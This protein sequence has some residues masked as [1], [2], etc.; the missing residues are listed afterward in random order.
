[1]LVATIWPALTAA[2][3]PEELESA[4]QQSFHSGMEALVADLN[5]SSYRSLIRSIDQADM[6]ERIYG[7]RLIDQ[8]VKKRFG[9]RLEYTW[10]DLIRSGFPETEDG[11]AATLLGVES[12]GD[13]GRAVVRFDLPDYQFGYHEYDLRLG[14]SGR[15]FV[16]DWIDYLDGM[17]FSD[18]VGESLVMGMPSKPAMRK[19]LDFRNVSDVELFQ[20]GELLKAA[21]DG[22]LTRYLEI[23]E[24]MEEKFQRQRIV[25]ENTVRVAKRVRKRR[26]MLAGLETM[27]K[28]YPDDPLYALMLLDYYFPAHKY[29]EATRALLGA[30]R[31]LG[32]D[33]AAMEARLSAAALVQGNAQ[34]AAGYA[35]RALELEPGLELAWW[36]ALNARATLQDFGAAVEALEFLE[37]EF[38][39]ELTPAA[40]GRDPTY[41]GLLASAE[42]GAWRESRQ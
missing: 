21:R 25:V 34:D 2:Q 38:G 20:F 7:L 1:L 28:Y 32:F 5:E 35:E 8:Q 15:L 40:L 19:L 37:S 41:K 30:Y 18:A 36:S 24:G 16:V 4:R 26:S 33:D 23:L 12:R 17:R 9:E 13:R 39:Y 29:E 11:L 27:A 42:Y 31:K 10:E 22:R 6:L 3:S 14:D